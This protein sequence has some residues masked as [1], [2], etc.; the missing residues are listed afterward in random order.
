MKVIS[1]MQPWAT[2]V[3]IGAKKIETRSWNTKHRGEILIHASKKMTRAQRVLADSVPFIDAFDH[4]DVDELHLGC[5]IGKVEIV[6]TVPSEILN[7]R[8]NEKANIFNSGFL[9][10]NKPQMEL[11]F[12]DYSPG[13]YGWLLSNAVYFDSHHYQVNGSRGLW[14]FDPEICL[15]CGCTGEDACIHPDFGSCWWVEPYL[16]SHC[17]D[18]ITKKK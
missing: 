15:S 18:L 5:I 4:E 2:L 1:L 12:G 16:C 10:P 8:L 7:E 9:F 14:D 11:A 17:T 3:V 13:R 6:E